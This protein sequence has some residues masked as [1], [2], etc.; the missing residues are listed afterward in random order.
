[1]AAVAFP[2]LL[3]LSPSARADI[4]EVQA[5]TGCPGSVGGGLCNGSVPYNLSTLLSGGIS[6]VSGTQKFVVKDTMGSFSF[7]YSGSSGDNGSCQI[8]GGAT[9][10]FNACTGT[11]RDGTGFSL[12]HDDA[13]HPGMNP[14]TVIKFTALPGQCTNAH[15]CTFDLG[16]VSWQGAG[17]ATVPDEPCTLSLL[18]IG[19][20]GLV[21]FA[22]RRLNSWRS[23][24]SIP[25]SDRGWLYS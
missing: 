8:N 9:S 21:G 10:F 5:A 12:G 24:P 2:A 22:R 25:I 1:M 19:L 7:V 6:I 14:P 4:I 17:T 13:N 20:F 16:F 18:A 3:L 23:I 11:N 15:P